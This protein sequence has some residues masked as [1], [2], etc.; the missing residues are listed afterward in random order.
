MTDEGRRTGVH[1]HW[2][3]DLLSEP[4]APTLTPLQAPWWTTYRITVADEAIEF[5]RDIGAVTPV[6][7]APITVEI[8]QRDEL[9]VGDPCTVA[10]GPAQLSIMGRWLTA[11]QAHHLAL[12]IMTALADITDSERHDDRPLDRQVGLANARATT[13]PFRVYDLGTFTG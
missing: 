7:D 3:V 9:T 11:G 4:S 8:V 12:L 2:E 13:I 5:R 1:Q 6:G 10:R